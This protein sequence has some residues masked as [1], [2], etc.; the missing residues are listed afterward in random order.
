M[1]SN[2][3]RIPSSD[4]MFT[5]LCNLRCKYCFEAKKTPINLK[6][7][8]YL[9]YLKAGGTIKFFL[10][11]GEPFMNPQFMEDFFHY[12]YNELEGPPNVVKRIKMSVRNVITNGTLIHKHI[13]LIKK[14]NLHMQISMDGIKEAHDANRIDVRGEGTWDRVMENIKLCYKEGISWS[15]HGVV[16]RQTLPLLSKNMIFFFELYCKYDPRGVN[17]AIRKLG[18]NL[19]QIIFEEDWTDA[20]VDILIQQIY[21]VCQYLMLHPKLDRTQKRRAIHNF[22]TRRGGKCGAG[23]ALMA[24]DSNMN[25]FPCHRQADNSA[26]DVEEMKLGNLYKGD[27]LKNFKVYNTFHRIGVSH[28]FVYGYKY[29]NHAYRNSSFYWTNW[30]PS[31]N[32]F[33]SGNFN[34][35][36]ANAKYTV[37]HNEVDR[38]ITMLLKYYGIRDEKNRG[39]SRQ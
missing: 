15:V 7:E 17:E 35:Y 23:T 34:P 20:D 5:S 10:F 30:C 27:E 29:F 2:I 18:Q 3:I 38:F 33:T 26:F 12:V 6:F 36:Y 37:M 9:P 8:D 39:K 14:Y 32:A 24:V 19:S 4:L 31:T 13:D 11:G 22:L 25:V 1:V 28:R 16:N 21:E